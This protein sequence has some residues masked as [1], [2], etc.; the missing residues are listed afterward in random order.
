MS[1]YLGVCLCGKL[2]KE[3]ELS[4][5]LDDVKDDSNVWEFLCVIILKHRRS[6]L[7]NQFRTVRS[8]LKRYCSRKE[9]NSF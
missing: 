2:F 4:F 3:T 7:K 9:T 6:D 5:L 8:I 1:L